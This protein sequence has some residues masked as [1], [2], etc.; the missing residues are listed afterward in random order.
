MLDTFCSM[1]QYC[2]FLILQKVMENLK[3]RT[4]FTNTPTLYNGDVQK[5]GLLAPK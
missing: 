4:M 3:L 2:M 1:Q 5:L